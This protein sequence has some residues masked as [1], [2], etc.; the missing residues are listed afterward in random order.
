MLII[1]LTGPIGHGKSS[2]ADAAKEV[3]PSSILIESSLVIAEVANALHTTTKTIPDS[4][5]IEAINTWLKPLPLILLK[6]V[7]IKC[8]FEDI[9]LKTK[10]VHK[11]PGDYKKL[12]VHLNN[13]T[14]QPKMLSQL[15][16]PENKQD[17]RPILQWLGGYLVKK[18]DSGIWFK[19]I[20]KRLQKINKKG[21]ALCLIAGLR[22]PTDAQYVR[23]VGGKVIKIYRPG[24][25]QFDVLDPTER[26]RSAITVDATLVSNGTVDD[27]K[28]CAKIMINDLANNNLKKTYYAR[29]PISK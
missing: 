1:G 10:E 26:E 19:E 3:L 15:I 28:N 18:I 20:I 7:H 17:Y 21:Y 11:H 8:T 25:E 12:F 4:K 2:L 9:K 22:F 13:L 29:S 27:I 5:D 16:T 24:V 6:T 23:Q 14:N